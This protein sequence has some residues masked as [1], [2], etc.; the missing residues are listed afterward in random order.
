MAMSDRI[1]VARQ[2]KVVE[3]FSGSEATEEK[4]Y[5]AIH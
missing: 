1:L 3:E 4:M 5:A 2:W